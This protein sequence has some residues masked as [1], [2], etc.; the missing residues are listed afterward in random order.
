MTTKNLLVQTP[1]RSRT[2]REANLRRRAVADAEKGKVTTEVAAMQ[3]W[4]LGPVD[5]RGEVADLTLDQAS[6]VDTRPR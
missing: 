4:A 6:C 3:D 5:R 2:S 1:L